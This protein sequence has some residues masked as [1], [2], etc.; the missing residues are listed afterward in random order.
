MNVIIGS[1]H[2]GFDLKEE[3]KRSLTE[4][5]EYPVTDMGTFS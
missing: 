4:K 1:D 5:G 2:A 3:I